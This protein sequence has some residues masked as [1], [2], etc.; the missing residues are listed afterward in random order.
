MSDVLQ[1]IEVVIGSRA[2][3]A[4]TTGD[5]TQLKARF[6]VAG[7]AIVEGSMRAMRASRRRS[8]GR[9]NHRRSPG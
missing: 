2:A 3:A 4:I 8:A 1:A 9:D 6:M 5:D 7:K